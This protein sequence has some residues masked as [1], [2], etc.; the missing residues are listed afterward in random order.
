MP[1]AHESSLQ[2]AQESYPHELVIRDVVYYF[3]ECA[4]YRNIAYDLDY[5]PLLGPYWAYFE[6]EEE[7]VRQGTM[8]LF[9]GM[10]REW[11]MGA[12]M[13]FGTS[14]DGVSAHPL[15]SFLAS[16]LAAYEGARSAP[17]AHDAPDTPGGAGYLYA[18]AI[19]LCTQLYR[20]AEVWW[21]R[22]DVPADLIAR[23]QAYGDPIGKCRPV[24]TYGDTVE[25]DEV[26]ADLYERYVR[27]YFVARAT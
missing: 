23:L 7:L 18:V 12:G 20:E 27:P 2:E 14:P 26:F 15:R 11:L 4:A 19:S 6:D 5:T 10:L 17:D 1:S 16:L 13:P 22:V 3:H 21:Q 24:E 8:L 25:W 9:I